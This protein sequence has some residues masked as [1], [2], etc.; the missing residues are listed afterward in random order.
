MA[1]PTIAAPTMPAPT[2]QP[3]PNGLASACV[4]LDAMAPVTARV[5]RARAA[6]L[7]LIDMGNS[8]RFG[9]GPSWS[10]RQLDGASSNPVRSCLIK[11]RQG[12][13][14]QGLQKVNKMASDF[15]NI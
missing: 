2:P 14:F 3:K 11:S 4:V 12:Q 1:L 6:M 7:L 9:G 8:I 10:A 13:F 15:R 5:A